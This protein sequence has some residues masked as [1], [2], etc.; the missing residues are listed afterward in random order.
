MREN[1]LYQAD[2]S[3]EKFQKKTYYSIS[4][5]NLKPGF[6]TIKALSTIKNTKMIASLKTIASKEKLLNVENVNVENVNVENFGIIP[7]I[8]C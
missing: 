8:K 6:L 7:I 5:T 4:E 2:V 3:S 1:T